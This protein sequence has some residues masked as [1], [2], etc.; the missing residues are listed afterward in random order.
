MV[1]HWAVDYHTMP[2]ANGDA[3]LS[4]RQFTPSLRVSPELQLEP[5]MYD[6]V[7]ASGLHS[8]KRPPHEKVLGVVMHE[9]NATLR[10]RSTT[11]NKRPQSYHGDTAMGAITE[12]PGTF[13]DELN[14]SLT[15]RRKV[16]DESENRGRT[17][18]DLT[19]SRRVLKPKIP[20]KPKRPADNGL[21]TLRN[22]KPFA[23][24]NPEPFALGNPVPRP[25]PPSKKNKPVFVRTPTNRKPLNA[26]SLTPTTP[27]VLELPQP[28]LLES[29][30]QLLL[31]SP[32]LAAFR[33][34]QPPAP[35][36]TAE[37]DAKA[38][39]GAA[40]KTADLAVPS[41]FNE[42]LVQSTVMPRLT[43]EASAGGVSETGLQASTR[44]LRHR[45]CLHRA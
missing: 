16:S 3:T 23:L 36:P 2:S 11:P 24:G 13:Q 1:E 25:P 21:L 39:P 19:A 29:P 18:S 45:R 6:A 28:S 7:Q 26:L 38:F 20:P 27:L 30:Q 43:D 41:C 37:E 44:S 42:P 35:S 15:A 40:N 8:R 22:L 14:A 10:S 32:Q 17:C 31:E 4:G 9:L 34:P 5:D 33:S 12:T